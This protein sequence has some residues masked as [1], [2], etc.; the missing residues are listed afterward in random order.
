MTDI[1]K[2]VRLILDNVYTSLPCEVVEYDGN[3][4]FAKCK[5]LVKTDKEGDTPLIRVPI[6]RMVGGSVP[7]KAGMKIPVWFTKYSLGE[8]VVSLSTKTVKGPLECYQFTRDS[9][10]GLPFL[11]DDK[12]N[13]KMPEFVEF[14]TK[15]IFKEDVVME[16]TLDVT[17]DISAKANV[18]VSQNLQVTG[19][20]TIQGSMSAPNYD[21]HKHNDAEGR[22]TTTPI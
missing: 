4:R 19:N 5:L 21:S 16:K 2:Y 13:I 17:Q 9:A 22:P 14:D 12:L 7:L 10:Y 3:T 6:L 1:E 8:F 11:F 15:V 20:G 18:N